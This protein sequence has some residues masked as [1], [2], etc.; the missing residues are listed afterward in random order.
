MGKHVSDLLMVN[1]VFLGYDAVGKVEAVG[2]SVSMFDIGDV[3][4]YAGTSSRPV[5]MLNIML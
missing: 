5:Q 1:S 2:Q 3:V 4:F